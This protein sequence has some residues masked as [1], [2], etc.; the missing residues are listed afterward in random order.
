MTLVICLPFEFLNKL[1]NTLKAHSLTA[2]LLSPNFL[3][4]TGRIC[5]IF[6]C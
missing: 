5:A 4:Q 2:I 6:A 3:M 1:K